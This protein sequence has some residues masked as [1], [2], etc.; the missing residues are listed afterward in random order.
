M[1]GEKI[2]NAKRSKKKRTCVSKAEEEKDI[3][4][5]YTY[6]YTYTERKTERGKYTY[7][8]IYTDRE[9]EK[10]RKRNAESET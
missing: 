10:Y 6:V 4:G 5:K 3:G 1:H 9:G 8:Y 7:V 2:R